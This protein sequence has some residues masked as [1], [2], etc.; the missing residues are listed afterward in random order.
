MKINVILGNV[1][2][3]KKDVMPRTVLNVSS[4][5]LPRREAREVAMV[6]RHG[7]HFFTSHSSR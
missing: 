2:T 5:K 3:C 4:H 6:H 7:A 1:D